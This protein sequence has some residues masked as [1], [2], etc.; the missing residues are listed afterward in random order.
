MAHLLPVFG[1]SSKIALISWKDL[2]VYY[3]IFRRIFA[4]SSK[5]SKVFLWGWKGYSTCTI[6][7]YRPTS[8]SLNLYSMR[9]HLGC[10]GHN[11]WPLHCQ[12]WHVALGILGKIVPKA[13]RSCINPQT[14]L[15]WHSFLHTM[16]TH[17]SGHGGRRFATRAK[18]PCTDPVLLRGFPQWPGGVD[19]QCRQSCVGSV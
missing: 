18:Q 17:R 10:I 1:D 15:R 6:R 3:R 16:F 8:Y 9:Y 4:Q 11:W 2:A 14:V 5:M 12:R 13:F 7:T 19:H